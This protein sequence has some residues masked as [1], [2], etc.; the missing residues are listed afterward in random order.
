MAAAGLAAGVAGAALTARWLESLLFE[1][2]PSDPP[3]YAAV[4]SGLAAIALAAVYVPA[5]RA[6]RLDPATILRAE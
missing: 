3:T 4:V 1:V 5:R 6:A 2:V